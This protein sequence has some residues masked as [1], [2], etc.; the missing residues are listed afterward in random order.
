MVRL[1]I[2]R[3]KNAFANIDS[4]FLNTPQYICPTLSGALGCSI[5]LKVETLNP[6]RCF[7]GRGIETVLSRLKADTGP[8]AAVCASAGNLGQAL[9]YSGRQR[10]F[11]IT[12]TASAA[13][14][15]LKIER[16]KALGA[17]VILVDGQIEEALNAAQEFSQAHGAFLVEDSKNLD[18]CEGAGTIGMELLDLP[19]PLDA[20][21]VSLGG[22]AMAS[23]I[24]CVM[25][26]RSPDTTVINVQP[27]NAPAMTNSFR[28][29]R[30]VEADAPHTIADGVAGRYCSPEAL[31]DLL[32]VT[33]EALLVSEQSIIEAM[34]LLYHYSGLVVEPAAALGVACILEN[35]E[36][37]KD[38]CV[39]TILCGSN[40]APMDFKDWVLGRA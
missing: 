13:A 19:F 2:E 16:M 5:V 14:N 4:T 11:D 21:V 1:D 40:V 31:A 10:G 36:R 25:K 12:V 17:K 28:A 32:A 24:G 22:G 26:S 27:E 3:I 20:I 18:T 35:P 33:D 15:P 7:K 6:I 8:K 30:V 9:A 38:K 29:G 23:G 37:F 39:A 34:R